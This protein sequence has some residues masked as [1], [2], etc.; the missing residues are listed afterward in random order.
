MTTA[1]RSEWLCPAYRRAAGSV[2]AGDKSRLGTCQP[3]CR[4][5]LQVMAGLQCVGRRHAGHAW[6]CTSV[7]P[8]PLGGTAAWSVTTASYALTSRRARNHQVANPTPPRTTKPSRGL[9]LPLTPLGTSGVDTLKLNP[10]GITA[11]PSKAL[12][13]VPRL[14]IITAVLAVVL[15]VVGFH[16]TVFAIPRAVD[17]DRRGPG[18]RL[19]DLTP[20]QSREPSTKHRLGS[21]GVRSADPAGSRCRTAITR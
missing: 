11:A 15:R 6:P 1:C 20:P 10:A 5:L 3:C 14:L 17:R 21:F 12:E 19:P 13:V 9:T 4:G 8:R 18:R 16:A 2:L 7:G